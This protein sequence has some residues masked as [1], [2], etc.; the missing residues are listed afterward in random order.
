MRN[1]QKGTQPQKAFLLP[2][3]SAPVMP[4]DEKGVVGGGGLV[5][6]VPNANGGVQAAPADTTVIDLRPLNAPPKPA[7][8]SSKPQ[9]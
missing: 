9:Q 4:P 7:A 5:K 8:D 2:D 6:I 1:E 3:M